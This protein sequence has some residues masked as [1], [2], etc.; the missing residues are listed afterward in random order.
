MHFYE[1]PPQIRSHF[2]YITN[3]IIWTGAGINMMI[4]AV[5]WFSETEIWQG[6]LTGLVTFSLGIFISKTRFKKIIVKFVTHIQSLPEKSWFFSFQQLRHYLLLTF[7]MLLGITLRDHSGLD[8]FYL[9]LIYMIMGTTLF[10]S[11]YY[12]YNQFR[13]DHNQNIDTLD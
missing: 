11:S 12:F 2:H 5:R 10:H 4:I 13:I 1:L 9:S 8:V 3:G 6:L 7:M